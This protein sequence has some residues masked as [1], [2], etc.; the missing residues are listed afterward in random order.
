M[1][2]AKNITRI[3]VKSMASAC[4]LALVLGLA[5]QQAAALGSTTYGFYNIT[6]NNTINEVD[7]ETNLKVEVIELTNPNQVRFQFTNNSISSLTDV[8]FDD[9]SLLGISSIIDSGAGV[10]FSQGAT[11]KD[12]P[13]GNDKKYVNP[14]F[15][16]TAGFSADADAPVA[17]NGVT[18]GEWLAIDFNLINGKTYSNVLSALAL[19]NNGG[20]GD[21]RIGVH[22]QG[23]ANGG[24]E[25]FINNVSPVP[26]ADAWL[27]MVAGLGLVGFMARRRSH[28]TV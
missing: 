12:L 21:L 17:P 9:G 28:T 25:S 10:S 11:P 18:N 16:V 15:N 2:I 19:P 24:S 6:H 4:V 1:K 13:G 22:V 26:E 8:Y 3:S 5:S 23:F 20:T 14:T 7:G 27:M